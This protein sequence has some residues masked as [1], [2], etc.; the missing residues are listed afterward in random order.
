LRANLSL[1]KRRVEFLAALLI[2]II[3]QNTSNLIRLA[4]VLDLS[5]KK[6]SKYRRIKR[7]F[8]FAEIDFTVFARLIMKIV[9]PTGKYILA[10]DGTEWKYGKVWVKIRM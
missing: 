4:N 5:A 10:L 8:Q 7:F 2:A 3:Q 1:D 9:C 6:D